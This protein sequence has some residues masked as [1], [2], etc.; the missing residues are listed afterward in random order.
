MGMTP[1]EAAKRVEDL[2]HQLRYHAHRYY[3]LDAPEI[4]DEE[5]DRLFR[6]LQGLEAEYDLTALDSPT[7]RVGAPV[8]G[9]FP[10]SRHEQAM[11]SLANIMP[12]EESLESLPPELEKFHERLLKRVGLGEDPPLDF[13]AEPKFDGLAVNLRYEEG[14]LVRAATRGDGAVGD[15]VTENVRTIR[16]VPLRLLDETPPRLLE[17]RGEIYISREG[18]HRLNEQAEKALALEGPS[19][20]YRRFVNPRNAAAGSLR[21]KDPRITAGRELDI[22]CYALGAMEAGPDLKLQS[23]LLARLRDWGF[24]VCERAQ[25]VTGIGGCWDYYRETHAERDSLAYETDGVVYKVNDL[26]LQSRLGQ[27][28][29]TPHWAVAHKF[30][31]ETASAVLEAVS[32]QVGRTGV[33]TPVAHLSPVQVGGVTVRRATLHNLGFIRDKG[34]N[35][36]DTI[37]V[38]RAGDVIPEIVSVREPAAAEESQAVAPPSVCPVCGSEVIREEDILY[39]TGGLECPAQIRSTLMHFV[40][41]DAMDI[42]NLGEEHIAMFVEE[43]QLRHVDD[44]YQLKKSDIERLFRK[45]ARKQ[46]RNL[47]RKKIEAWLNAW[48]TLQCGE[49]PELPVLL[50]AL[51]IPHVSGAQVNR[52]ATGFASLDA[53]QEATSEELNAAGLNKAARQS[54]NT[55]LEGSLSVEHFQRTLLGNLIRRIPGIGPKAATALAESF[56]S[57]EA[58]RDAG[59]ADLSAPPSCNPKTVDAVRK[60]FAQMPAPRSQIRILFAGLAEGQETELELPRKITDN[61]NRSRSVELGRLIYALGIRGVG[62]V[63]AV[64]LA[65]VF[66]SMEQLMQA[67]SE[68]LLKIPDI[69]PVIAENIVEFIA[70]PANR[71]VI[72]RL[73]E[74]LEVQAPGTSAATLE[75]RI[76]VLT[77]TFS[78]IERAQVRKELEARGAKVGT[79]VSANTSAV[80]AGEKPGG[81]KI[82]RA[83]AL[84]IQIIGEAELGELLDE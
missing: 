27:D 44:F 43:G 30:P 78:G 32:F 75:G 74:E 67:D 65:R 28:A 68:Q 46:R 56:P 49:L 2:R 23:D 41:R 40:S 61:I 53:L 76:Y 64:G 17:V 63:T 34:L 36:G 73:L 72:E 57:L 11:L 42:E 62:R 29:R 59:R 18:F 14:R 6:E 5:Y 3:V 13:L 15:D 71:R 45:K 12:P 33:V 52:L 69:G 1:A 37:E 4:E 25:V 51:E 24:R 9:G 48:E 55:F 22:Y 21:Q 54:I 16:S 35:I 70:Q 26:E 84:G 83:T 79:T 47:N 39:C 7:Q 81:A 82:D 38:R 19:S 20:G 8:E 80:I 77:G 58:L 50:T 60:F 66:G 31:A 10:P